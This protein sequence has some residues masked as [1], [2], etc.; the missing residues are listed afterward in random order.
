[1]V[2]HKH[3]TVHNVDAMDRDKIVEQLN[4]FIE[5][6]QSRMID[7]TPEENIPEDTNEGEQIPLT[8]DSK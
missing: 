7:V 5:K 6:A 2:D 3:V 4:H 8:Y 1:M